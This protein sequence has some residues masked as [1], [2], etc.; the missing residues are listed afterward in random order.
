MHLF[1]HIWNVQ[2]YLI[3]ID[4]E[5]HLISGCSTAFISVLLVIPKPFRTLMT[6][7][8]IQVILNRYQEVSI[9]MW[10]VSLDIHCLILYV[11]QGC[12]PQNHWKGR[13]GEEGM[14]WE[15]MEGVLINFTFSIPQFGGDKIN[16]FER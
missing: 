6:K 15:G 1:L 16:S 12:A 3:F 7:I 10:M 13:G 8:I 11:P 14:G 4:F 9:L 5:K 2:E